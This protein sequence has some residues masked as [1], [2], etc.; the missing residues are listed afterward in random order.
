V[1]R[2]GFAVTVHTTAPVGQQHGRGT[3]AEQCHEDDEKTKVVPI[4][5][6]QNA[7]KREFE[8]KRR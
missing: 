5:Y 7:R 6:R 8:Q 2:K 3:E 1:V 4:G